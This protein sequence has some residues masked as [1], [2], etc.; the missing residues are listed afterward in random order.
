MEALIREC[1]SGDRTHLRSLIRLA[2]KATGDRRI[3][4]ELKLADAVANMRVIERV[5]ASAE[6]GTWI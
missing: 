4:A 5:L 1:P 3:K 6:K 2:Q